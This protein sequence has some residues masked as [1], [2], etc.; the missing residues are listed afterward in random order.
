MHLIVVEHDLLAQI[1]WRNLTE[2]TSVRLT[3]AD[4]L[5]AAAAIVR[6]KPRANTEAVVVADAERVAEAGESAWHKLRQLLACHGA[7][8]Y[9]YSSSIRFF[10]LAELLG[11]EADG[12][13]RRPF[14]LK[15]LTQREEQH[16]RPHLPYSVTA[17]PPPPA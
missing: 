13:L 2:E 6:S 7:R 8:L 14:G 5:F 4:D 15:E 12:L 17:P 9:V 11:S 16:H 3:F 10:A 1:W